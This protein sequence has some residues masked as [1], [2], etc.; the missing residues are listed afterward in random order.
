MTDAYDLYH[1]RLNLLE[2][3]S[4]EYPSTLS[5]SAHI[6]VQ[7]KQ[8]EDTPLRDLWEAAYYD[9][10]ILQ[11]GT[12]QDSWLRFVDSISDQPRLELTLY[13]GKTPRGYA[14]I[15][16]DYDQHCGWCWSVQWNFVHPKYRGSSLARKVLAVLRD[17]NRQ[18]GIPYAYSQMQEGNTVKITYRGIG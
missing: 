8:E 4:G 2:Q 12:V 11:R 10:K 17:L 7:M 16:L 5:P 15:V 6:E 13:V 14:C 3:Y 18:T 9:T 1:Q